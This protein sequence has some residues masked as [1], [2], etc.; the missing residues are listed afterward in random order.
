MLEARGVWVELGG[1][2]L[3]SDID[4]VV[5]PG[6]TTVLIGPNG[7]GKTTLL[8]VL[9]G[10]IAPSRGEARLGAEPLRSFSAAELARRRAVVPQASTVAFPFTVREVVMLGVT[11]PGFALHDAAAENSVDAA[12]DYVGLMPLA[13]RFYATLSGGERQRVHIA[14][15]LCQLAAGPRQRS[16]TRCFLLDEPTASL[17]LGHQ[18]LVLDAMRR[19]AAQGHVVLAIVH[20]LNLAA[21]IADHLVLLAGGRVARS[22]A[23]EDVL[24]DDVLSAA[25]GCRVAV[26][27]VPENGRPFVLPPAALFDGLESRGVIRCA[28][29]EPDNASAERVLACAPDTD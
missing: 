25:Y 7:A 18:G 6:R 19:Q 14:R 15:A 3:L 26:N 16:E 21:A 4:V 27:R 5:A 29:R 9:S 23:P 11:V 8:R 20:D 1:H 10:E 17:D 12:L 28:A 22:G 2:A 24:R 13:A